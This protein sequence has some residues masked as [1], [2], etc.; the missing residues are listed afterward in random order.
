[1]VELRVKSQFFVTLQIQWN[2]MLEFILKKLNWMDRSWQL[3]SEG[4]LHKC[5]EVVA[6]LTVPSE[7]LLI[8]NGRNGFQ[9]LW[10]E[11]ALGRPFAMQ[12]PISPTTKTYA[13][14]GDNT[15]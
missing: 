13:T 3:Q 9:M 11:L 8:L 15:G 12:Y 14:P 1:M 5:V 2:Q 6:K 4:Y 7:L 10:T